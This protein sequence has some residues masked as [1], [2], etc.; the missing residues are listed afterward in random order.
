MSGVIITLAA[1]FPARSDQGD[2][3]QPPRLEATRFQKSVLGSLKL[4]LVGSK[5]CLPDS[6]FC[7]LE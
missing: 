4:E 6:P 2:E 1:S 3:G 7:Q 5:V